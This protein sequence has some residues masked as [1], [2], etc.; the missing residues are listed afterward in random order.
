MSKN[1]ENLSGAKELIDDSMSL[2]NFNEKFKEATK[3]GNKYRVDKFRKGFNEDGRFKSFS[4]EVYFS[5]YT[6][7]YGDS[8]VCNFLRINK[9]KEVA[10]ALIEYLNS[11]EEA[12]LKGMADILQA[13]SKG[14]LDKARAEVEAATLLIGD[15]EGYEAESNA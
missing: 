4:T 15:I 2:S 7:I 12:V 14:L 8:S 13:K 5:A 1:F 11:N 3:K 6:G 10:D 9:T